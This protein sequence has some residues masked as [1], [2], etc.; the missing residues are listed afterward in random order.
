MK[1]SSLYE[2]TAH[3][4]GAIKYRNG[5][6]LTVNWASFDGLVKL[7]CDGEIIHT[8][9]SFEAVEIEPTAELIELIT[10]EERL[11]GEPVSVDGFTCWEINSG[12]AWVITQRDWA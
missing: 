10:D 3:E 12:E 1:M 4:S 11:L 5:M 7:F 9:E 2:L 6:S 8:G